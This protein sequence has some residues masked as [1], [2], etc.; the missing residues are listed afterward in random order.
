MVSLWR[1]GTPENAV[2]AKREV[3]FISLITGVG[4]SVWFLRVPKFGHFWV[5]F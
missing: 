5:R 3:A 4:Y 2:K 1:L